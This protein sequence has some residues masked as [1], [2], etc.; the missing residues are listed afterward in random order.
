MTEP[1]MP[2]ALRDDPEA[3]A[4]LGVNLATALREEPGAFDVA[5]GATRFS[6]AIGD[7]VRPRFDPWSPLSRALSTRAALVGVALLGALIGAA[8]HAALAPREARVVEVERVV[9]R[10]VER[11]VERVVER[12]VERIV[13]RP[14]ERV[15][16]RPL[17]PGVEV[18]ARR[19][20]EAAAQT[21]VSAP[22]A[23]PSP[24]ESA[25]D[26]ASV[27]T[28]ADELGYIERATAALANRRARVALDEVERYRAAYPSARFDV[29][30]RA[31][32]ERA[33]ALADP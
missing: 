4:R 15:V 21:S 9:E 19:V 20:D 12:V 28:L 6:A 17:E 10:V 3:A 26:T 23:A 32:E 5:R 31:L 24:T 14:V 1:G 7:G 8:V 25:T 30:A 11:P 13:E 22:S 27:G 2:R 18:R 16:E 29:E 33:R